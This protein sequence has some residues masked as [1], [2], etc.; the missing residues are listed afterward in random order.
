MVDISIQAIF[1]SN[2]G[3]SK[4]S[5]H[6]LGIYQPLGVEISYLAG[7]QRHSCLPSA[8]HVFCSKVLQTPSVHQPAHLQAGCL[9]KSS[10]L[11]FTSFL[12]LVISSSSS[13]WTIWIPSQ[14]LPRRK[15]DS[16]PPLTFSASYVAMLS[17][18]AFVL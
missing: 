3:S 17:H 14:K 18:H 11:P 9:P 6:L 2:R 13:L 7:R 4:N 16:Y 5:L 8:V 15:T 1:A 10:S 12:A